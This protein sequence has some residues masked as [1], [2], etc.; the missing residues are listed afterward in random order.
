[1]DG[2]IL[3]VPLF[4]I[5]LASFPMMGVMANESQLNSVQMQ[6]QQASKV[7][8]VITDTEGAVIGA[9]ITEKGNKSNGVVSD[10]NGNFVI[11]VKPGA[12]LVIS[13]LGYKTVEVK[14]VPG[15]KLNITQS[16]SQCPQRGCRSR[17][18]YTEKGQLD[19]CCRHGRQQTIGRTSGSQCRTGLARCRSRFADYTDKR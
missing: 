17:F 11:S 12:T 19:R 13:Y 5:A 1:M 3:T 7:S 10:L 8:G 9:S 16:R 2:R 4:S 14:A 15:K 18:R 6:Q